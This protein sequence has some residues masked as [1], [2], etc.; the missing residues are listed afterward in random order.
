MTKSEMLLFLL[1]TLLFLSLG[2]RDFGFK[3]KDE[4]KFLS[5]V[6]SGIVV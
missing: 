2:P 1:A 3:E 5:S 4:G 6:S